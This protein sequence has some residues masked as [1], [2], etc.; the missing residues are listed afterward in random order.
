V[1]YAPYLVAKESIASIM[2]SLVLHLWEL[3]RTKMLGSCHFDLESGEFLVLL[4]ESRCGKT[5]LLGINF[6]F[7]EPRLAQS[8]HSLT[9]WLVRPINCFWMTF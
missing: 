7:Q 2:P 6:R 3:A 5:T 8:W 9:P 1:D 4:G